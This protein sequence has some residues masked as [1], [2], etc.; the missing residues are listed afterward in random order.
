MKKK[1]LTIGIIAMLITMLVVLTG[2]GKTE[3]ENINETVTDNNEIRVD[4][5]KT[6]DYSDVIKAF[7]SGIDNKDS[8][9]IKNNINPLGF[10]YLMSSGLGT[11]GVNGTTF[12]TSS[13]DTD[14]KE[15]KSKANLTDEQIIN[16][17]IS[18][19]NLKEINDYI[20]NNV[21]DENTNWQIDTIS[22]IQ[23]VENSE[24]LFVVTGKMKTSNEFTFYLM[25]INNQYKI[26]AYDIKK[27]DEE[28]QKMQD[29]N[30]KVIVDAYNKTFDVY[31]GE[32]QNGNNVK[33]LIQTI[34]TRNI[35][36]TGKN[37]SIAVVIDNTKYETQEEIKNCN[38]LIKNSSTYKV[39][40]KYNDVGYI[41][42]IDI[43]TLN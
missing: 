2:C 5:G 39:E 23:K 15:I 31:C 32:N 28:F 24:L 9:K 21:L 29:N 14:Y 7:I 6:S 12:S 20:N 37:L 40:A 38:Q 17:E 35:E 27:T 41:S 18:D 3:N 10:V 34:I 11:V 43:T 19:E 1:I 8:E 22:E 16:Y 13:F 26:V 42:E 30:Q 33:N 25:N 4:K 36:N